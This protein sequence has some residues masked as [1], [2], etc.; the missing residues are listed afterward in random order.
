MSKSIG[1]DKG[2]SRRLD[3]KRK[4]K[5]LKKLPE[6]LKKKGKTLL[7]LKKHLKQLDID[8]PRKLN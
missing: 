8:R 4:S 1:I 7:K 2:K 3:Y 5:K 6:L